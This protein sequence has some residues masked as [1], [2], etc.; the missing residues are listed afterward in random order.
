MLTQYYSEAGK[1]AKDSTDNDFHIN[2]GSIIYDNKGEV[3][4]N[5]YETSFNTYLSYNEIPKN[6]VNAFVAID[7]RTFWENN[8]VDYKGIIRVGLRYVLSRGNE[9]HGE[10]MITQ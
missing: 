4:A 9:A 1:I 8:G 6:V 2:E 3:L 10:S 7:D 5:L